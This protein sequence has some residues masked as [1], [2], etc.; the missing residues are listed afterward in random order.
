VDRCGSYINPIYTAIFAQGK[1][2]RSSIYKFK[3]LSD[4]ACCTDNLF[5]NMKK[6]NYDYLHQRLHNSETSEE[7]QKVIDT[8]SGIHTVFVDIGER[9]LVTHVKEMENVHRIAYAFGTKSSKEN[10]GMWIST[11]CDTLAYLDGQRVILNDTDARTR[12]TRRIIELGMEHY[13]STRNDVC[14]IIRKMIPSASI[15]NELSTYL[16]GGSLY[17]VQGEYI[18][19]L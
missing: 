6:G 12:W 15:D 1:L 16:Q 18:F 14:N 9:R 3:D 19:S 13:G 5:S 8:T 11:G 7:M 17:L 4:I 10:M 2:G